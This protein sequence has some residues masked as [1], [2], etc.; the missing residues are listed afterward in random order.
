MSAYQKFSN[1]GA[2]LLVTIIFCSFS[3]FFL[4]H[5]VFKISR[6]TL[7]EVPEFTWDF[8]EIY[9]IPFT[10]ILLRTYLL[11]LYNTILEKFC[12]HPFLRVPSA[13]AVAQTDLSAIIVIVY[14]LTADW[15]F[16]LLHATNFP[17]SLSLWRF[18]SPLI[19]NFAL[20]FFITLTWL[21]N[22]KVM[23]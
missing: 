21:S 4:N 9:D 8:K 14:F 12:F 1:S 2:D 7:K 17:V 20:S 22:G 18:A 3:F 10:K 15:N 16:S 13:L 6:Y 19:F 11:H 23:T 5:P